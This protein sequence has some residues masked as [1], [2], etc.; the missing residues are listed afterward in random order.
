MP[1][2]LF[3]LSVFPGLLPAQTAPPEFDVVSIKP[4]AAGERPAQMILSPSRI[5]LPCYAVMRLMQNA[6]EIFAEG[7]V[8]P[9]NPIFP[10]DPIEG[11]PP[12][13]N[14]AT[15]TIDAK[16]QTPQPVAMMVGPMMR[17]LLED[18]FHLK[19][20]RE[21]RQVAAFLMTVAKSGA[22][23]KPSSPDSCRPMDPTDLSQAGPPPPGPK[24]ADPC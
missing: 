21:T 15:Y 3:V 9:L 14:S 24:S 17:A 19:L 20:H 13:V 6:Y 12:W 5:S 11:G 4:C 18:R 22:K 16:P 10:L 2:W 8:N 7:K 23:L 1:R